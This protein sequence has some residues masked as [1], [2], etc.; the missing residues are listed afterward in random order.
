MDSCPAPVAKEIIKDDVSAAVA[1]G[2]S[3]KPARPRLHGPVLQPRLAGLSLKKPGEFHPLALRLRT[4]SISDANGI[5][6]A[7]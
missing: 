4:T 1:I 3:V 2:K 5:H 6:L 7:S